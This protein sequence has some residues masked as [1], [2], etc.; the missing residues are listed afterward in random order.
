MVGLMNEKKYFYLIDQDGILIWNGEGKPEVESCKSLKRGTLKEIIEIH[1][2]TFN[3]GSP[4]DEERTTR[5][6]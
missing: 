1:R 6:R 3:E 2:K 5:F 4:Y